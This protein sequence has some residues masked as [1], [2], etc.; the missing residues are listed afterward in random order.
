MT[1]PSCRPFPSTM[2]SLFNGVLFFGCPNPTI[3]DS[4]LATPTALPPQCCEGMIEW[5]I[6]LPVHDFPHSCC[7]HLEVRVRLIGTGMPRSPITFAP[8]PCS[9]P[10]GKS[11]P[12]SFAACV[13]TS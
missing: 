11:F 10:R 1:C 6:L 7:L 5:L 2:M 4:K 13:A 8:I 9:F 3:R 12:F